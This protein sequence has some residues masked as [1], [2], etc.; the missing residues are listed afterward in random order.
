MR[1]VMF[2]TANFGT[3]FLAICGYGR[4]RYLIFTRVHLLTKSRHL[5]N[6]GVESYCAQIVHY[7]LVFIGIYWH[8][9]ALC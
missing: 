2:F 7:H 3:L 4:H 5:E 1:I 9:P 8:Q 6:H